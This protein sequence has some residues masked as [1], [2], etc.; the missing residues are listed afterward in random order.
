MIASRVAREF[1]CGGPSFGVSSGAT[2]ALHALDTAVR[3][4][5]REEIDAC[6][7]GGVDIASAARL[8]GV[9]ADDVIDEASRGHPLDG[10]SEPACFGDGAG[11]MIVKR[12][13]DAQR[14]GD[15]VY[16]L[17]HANPLHQNARPRQRLRVRE[18]VRS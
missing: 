17:I 11:A 4:L 8:R 18:Y 3:A 7:V 10:Q 12:L 6:L 2:S 5:R 16:A 9:I 15:R 13:S 1:G 14:D